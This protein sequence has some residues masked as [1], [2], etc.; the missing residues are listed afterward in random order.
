MTTLLIGYKLNDDF[1]DFLEVKENVAD[2]AGKKV[3]SL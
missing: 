3:I 2:V 1:T